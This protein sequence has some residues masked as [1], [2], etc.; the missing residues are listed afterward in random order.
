M[1][2]ESDIQK[3]ILK[4]LNIQEKTFAYR[5]H[6][7]GVPIGITG[8][9]RINYNK[10]IADILGVKDGKAF[11]MEVKQEGKRASDHQKAWLER[12]AGAHGAAF[13]VHSLD[14]ASESF[15]EL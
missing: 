1:Q 6:T 2:K 15:I 10:G 12:F 11:A 8:K 4:W 3:A 14:E 13:I 9:F 5:I 7:T